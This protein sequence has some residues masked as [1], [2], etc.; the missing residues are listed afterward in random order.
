VAVMAKELQGNKEVEEI[1]ANYM[2]ELLVCIDL[3][4]EYVMNFGADGNSVKKETMGGN[5][6]SIHHD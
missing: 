3:G 5:S 4:K 1:L 2:T 6:E